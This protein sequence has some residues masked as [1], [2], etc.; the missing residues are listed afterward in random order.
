MD[1]AVPGWGE[2]QV[3]RLIGVVCG[4]LSLL[5]FFGWG[6]RALR[7]FLAWARGIEGDVVEAVAA[8]VG[9]EE[10]AE[11][12][13]RAVDGDVGEVERAGGDGVGEFGLVGADVEVVGGFVG[14]R[15]N[16]RDVKGED[17]E[18]GDGLRGLSHFSRVGMAR[19]D[20]GIEWKVW[21]CDGLVW[22]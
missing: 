19:C 8:E 15:G 16:G 18:A 11:V 7:S 13:G 6:S 5:A 9:G 10:G 2:I 17:G 4:A 21:L 20:F 3:R 1:G 22:K 12:R 14:E